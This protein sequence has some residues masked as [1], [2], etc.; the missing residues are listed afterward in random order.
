ML[1][2]DVPEDFLVREVYV[3][4]FGGAWNL[5][6]L[7][8]REWNTED[9]LQWLA[10]KLR[11]PRK[12]FGVC[13]NKDKRAVTEQ[14]VTIRGA[15]REIRTPNEFTMTFL[16]TVPEP[17]H[18]GA[19]DGNV[20]TITVRQL[21]ASSSPVL[22]LVR[23]YFGEQRFGTRNDEIGFMLLRREYAAAASALGLPENSDPISALRSLPK[24]TLT[25]YVHA[26]QSRLWNDA[27]AALS[28]EQVTSLQTV[29][30]PGYGVDV[31]DAMQQALAARGLDEGCFV[32]RSVQELSVEGIERPLLQSVTQF[33][34]SRVHGGV[35]VLRFRLPPGQYAT[36]T[37]RQII[38]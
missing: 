23:N 2:K 1:L 14:Y 38:S 4:R 16:G 13:G 19:H 22:G 37:V 35:C 15:P 10:E 6:L 27:V 3:P 20:F 17:L 30:L 7:R 26:A 36:E 33:S 11:I 9:A 21:P 18:L 5:Y 28:D 12:H 32:N 29:P 8:K 31:P 24:R 34:A 25:L